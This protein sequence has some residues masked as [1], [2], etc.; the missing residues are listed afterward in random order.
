MRKIKFRAW[1][2]GL[3]KMEHD[4]FPISF[5]EYYIIDTKYNVV[6]K[7]R[8]GIIQQFTGLTDKNGKGKEVYEGDLIRALPNGYEPREIL[9]VYWSDSDFCWRVRG[10]KIDSFL[11]T[12]DRNFEVIGNIYETPELLEK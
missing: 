10:E 8:N 4:I 2:E 1:N 7:R 9:E 5:V 11:M 12:Q 3:N 6:L